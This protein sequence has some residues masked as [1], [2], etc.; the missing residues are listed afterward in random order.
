M[1]KKRLNQEEKARILALHEANVGWREIS[2]RTGRSKS[3]IFALLQ[4]A[5]KLPAGTV[6]PPTPVPGRPRK[7]TPTTDKLIRREIIK[8]PRMTALE[9]K[10]AHPDLLGNVAV[11]TI[12]E[13]CQKHLH[14]PMR[15]PTKKPLLTKKMRQGRLAFAKQHQGWTVQDW[16]KVMWSD[17][18]TFQCGAKR[19]GKL[20]RP[21]G[22]NK[23]DSRYI[24]TTVKHPDSV[25]IWGCFSGEQ[26]CGGFYVL[27]KNKTMNS[28]VYIQVL[29]SHLVNIFD[30][31]GCDFFQQDNAP[32]H[33]SRKTMKWLQDNNVC[34]LEWPRN[35]PDLN[36]IEQMWGHMKR[37]LE[38]MD[39]SS[40]P[41]LVRS[42]RELW[43]NHMPLDYCQKLSDSM[44]QRVKDVLKTRGGHTKY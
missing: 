26:G 19:R 42:L 3:A 28:E 30:Q 5:K 1:R 27:P 25:M 18:S 9:L 17:E 11:R 13:R 37:K 7:T 38:N 2:E 34:V 21:A 24:E 14:L 20:R 22:A 33:K 39:T 35:S 36:P 8:N 41:H 16:R 44:C 6:P 12:Q 23:F 4:R 40:V 29:E 10:K 15:T 31:H 32:C 43:D